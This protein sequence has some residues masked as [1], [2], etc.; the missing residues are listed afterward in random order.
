VFVVWLVAVLSLMHKG[1]HVW[2]GLALFALGV[3][4]FGE[5]ALFGWVMV[6]YAQREDRNDRM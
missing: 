4:L 2:S 6:R 3:V 5:M 1:E